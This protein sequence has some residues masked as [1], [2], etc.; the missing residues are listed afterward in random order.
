MYRQ[1]RHIFEFGR[2]RLDRTER[3]LFQDGAAVPLSP[4]LFDTLLVLV[5]NRGHLV[6]KNDLMQKVWNDDAVEENNLTQSI[7]ALRKVLGDNLDDPK[8][9][10]TI[11][12]RGYRFV[13]PV[14]E[15]MEEEPRDD[16]PPVTKLSGRAHQGGGL[17][18]VESV[19]DRSRRIAPAI[20]IGTVLLVLVGLAAMWRSRTHWGRQLQLKE[21]QLTTNSSEASL[22]A[23]AISP[24]GRYLAYADSAGLYV[25]VS[26]TGEIHTI[27]V[28]P[29]SVI[30]G[31][32]WFPDGTRLL[33]TVTGLQPN[34]D[35]VWVIS[36]LGHAPVQLLDGG[37]QAAVSPDGSQ[38]VFLRGKGK[39]LWL[40]AANGE[41]PHRI[42]VAAKEYLASPVWGW[43]S[44]HVAYG[45]V[46]SDVNK[47]DT[48][49]ETLDLETG[50]ITVSFSDPDITSG[51]PLPDGRLLYARNEIISGQSGASLLELHTDPSSGKVIGKPREIGRWPGCSISALGVTSDGKH[52]VALK[53]LAQA[54]VYV[55]DIAEHRFENPRRFTFNDRDDFA[56][57]W[58]PDSHYVLFASNRNGQWSSCKNV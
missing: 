45:R 30:G 53:G 25:R 55:G 35:S 52:L 43:D 36:I 23:A 24:D 11:P 17:A 20:V 4:R 50:K 51:I 42:L 7:S 34:V 46:F 28:P 9:I 12:K 10:E 1:P 21:T 47:F 27:S 49:V 56:S 16:R 37:N 5:E 3:F 48:V 13:A 31:L 57:D 41:L 22:I 38:I 44:K 33:A 6:E 15:V 8:F 19:Q 14:K 2:F 26:R 18:A 54:D 29:A 32:S 58:T 39:E 40:M